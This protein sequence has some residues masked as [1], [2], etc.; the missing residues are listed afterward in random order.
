[1]NL[2]TISEA[3]E[4]LEVSIKELLAFKEHNILKPFLENE[5][6]IFYTPEQLEEF[7]KMMTDK[8]I[9]PETVAP[10][11][12]LIPI[13]L[14]ETEEITTEPKSGLYGVLIK[15]LGNEF[16]SDEFI[17]NYFHSQLQES[18]TFTLKLPN[19]KKL[20]LASSALFILG[21]GLVTQ[22]SRVKYFYGRIEEKFQRVN[23]NGASVLAAQTSKVKLAGNVIFSLPVEFKQSANIAKNLTVGGT[24][25]FKGNLTAPN[26][27]YG[28]KAGEHILITG[29]ESQTPTISVD[30][31]GTVSSINGATGDVTLEAGTDISIDGLTINNISTLATI[32]QRGTCDSC[33][34][35]A[36]VSNNLTIT[37]GGNVSGDA[38][39]T[40]IVMPGVGGTG[41]TTYATGDLIYASASDTLANLPIGDTTGKVLTVDNGIP[42]WSNFTITSNGA[43]DAIFGSNVGIGAAP[44]DLDADFNRFALEVHGSIGPDQNNL[45]DLGSPTKQYRN[46]YLTGQTTSGGNITIANT[47]PTIFLIDTD[48]GQNQYTIN[49]DN[50]QFTITNSTTGANALTAEA[51]GN[52]DLAG[53]SAS[54]GCTIT[55]ASGDLTCSGNITTTNTSGTVGFF[56]RNNATSTL[57]PATAGDSITTGGNLSTT[58]TGAITSAGLLTA[59]NGF[60]QTTGTLNIS[61]NGDS[62]IDAAAN[63]L[64]ITS[65][66]FSTTATGINSTAIGATT[67][68]TGAFTSLSAQ[69]GTFSN[70]N[71]QLTLGT[72]STTIIN[73]AAGA[74]PETATIPALTGP[75]TFVMVSQSQTLDN[76]TIGSTGLIFSNAT[77]D[78][79]TGTNEDFTITPNGSGQ[80]VLSNIVRMGSL[81]VAGGAATTLCRDNASNEVTQCPANSSNVDLQQ[82]Y[83]AGNAINATDAF[84][85]I[86][87]SLDAASSRAF[88]LTNAGTAASA[89]VINDTNVATQNALEIQSGGVTS[90]T[91]DENGSLST[92]GNLTTTGTGTITS[93]GSITSQATSNQIILGT[94]NTTTISSTAP[95]ASRTAT[96]PALSGNDTFV[97]E[98]E[99]QTLANKTIGTSGLVF[100]AAATD[101]TTGTNEDFTISPNGTGQIVLSNTAVLG[102]LIAPTGNA[103]KTLCRDAVTQQITECPA[104]ANN[105][106]LQLAYDTGNTIT[107]TDGRNIDFTLASGLTTQTSFA[108]TNAGTGTAFVLNDTNLG[109]NTSLAIQSGG[110]TSLS[111]TENGTVSTSGNISTTGS[112]A[113]TSAGTLTAGNGLT[114]T[115]GALNLTATSGALA[116]SGLGAS[117][118]SAGT[119]NLT[120]TSGNFNTTATGINGTAIGA[121][122][123]S[124]G[125]FTTLSANGTVTFSTLNAAGVV[126]NDASGIL[127]TEAQLAPARGGTGVDASAAAN[128]QLLIG[129]GTGFTLATLTG[130]AN[131][132][133]VAN[134]SGSITLST[135]QDIATTSTP[136]FA[137]LTV[138]TTGL[139]IS[140]AATD[141]TTGANEDLTVAPNGTGKINLSNTTVLGTLPAAP[142]A[143][144]TLC[145]DDTT[146][147][148]TQ[149]PANAS[150][151][152]LQLA[153]DAGNTITTTTGRNI[154]FTLYDESSN[155]GTATSFDLTNAGTASAFVLNDTNA[156]TNT[157]LEIQS[158]GVTAMTINENGTLSTTG[159]ISTT[160]SGTITSAGTLT[161]SNGLTQ[162]TGTLNLTATAGALTLS[163]LSASSINTGANNLVFTSGNFNT[164]AT[165][166]NGTAIGAT[167]PSTGAFTTLSAQSAALTD[168]TNQL[169]LGTTN[170]TTISSAAPSAS[171]T[172]TIPAL[173]GND[174]FVFENQAQTL[175]NKTFVDT[176]TTFQNQTDNTKQFIFDLSP[177]TT[178]TT[179][180]ITVPDYDGTICLTT[181]NCAGSGGVV[182]GTG[183]QN[184]IT[185]FTVTGSTIGDSNI[186]DDGTVIT[187]F[188]ALNIGDQTGTDTLS[189]LRLSDASAGTQTINSNA[190]TFQGAY[191][192]GGISNNIGFSLQNTVTGTGPSYQL[193]FLDNGGSPVAALTNTG[194]LSLAGTTNQL[195][196][197]TT[198]TTTI[199]STAPAASRTATIPALTG[200]DTFVFEN[201]TQTLNNKTVGS[202][203]L[204]FSGAAPDIT[205]GTNEDFTVSPNG[206]GQI[207]LSNT[208]V[209]N[210]LP[211]APALATTLCRDDTT[212]EITQCPANA[213]NITLQLAYDKGN[214]ILTTDGRD[215]AFTLASGLTTPTSFTLTNAGTASAFVL[216]DTNGATNTAIEIQSGGVTAMT[217]N[218]NGTL[219]TTG[220]LSTTGSG[221]ITSAGTITAQA[222]TNQLVL[223]SGNTTTISSTAPAASRTATIP[224]LTGNDTFVFENET[225]TLTNKTIG[226][227]GLVFSNAATDITT[228]TN[229]DLTL[230]PD[231]TGKI[232]LSNTTVLNSLPAA[233][234]AGTTLCRDNTT[235]QITQC[236]ANA[237]NISLQLAYDA[238]NT[239][240]TTT[241]RDIAFTLY[242][243]SS[244]SGTATHFDLTNAGTGTAFILNDT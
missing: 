102:T 9:S 74:A 33:I 162:T 35:D 124:T 88:T 140:G 176:S 59:S 163:G 199:S 79:T 94:G 87:F 25:E 190:L 195:V 125:A 100:S 141:I 60:T 182:G 71:N 112:G 234:A 38:I 96:I 70:T 239:I 78:V 159:N 208:S 202:A 129:N 98:N 27:L 151:V 183:T 15:W 225:Q 212:H 28:L 43:N 150:N 181:G 174:T 45:Y 18:L 156:A 137:G 187:A 146:H 56:S 46:L 204:V 23:Q 166:I 179:R 55:D 95:L 130:T 105:T 119:N 53:G 107:T 82:A 206:S 233:G 138:G 158:G 207:V 213:A 132:V 90:M 92:S 64:T 6:G 1:M 17:K 8:D 19:R 194:T 244:N 103:V 168:T 3:A 86:A 169:V 5:E 117:S 30:L 173:T 113:I 97:F 154:S 152:T 227:T 200:N 83:N 66:N 127:S 126:I 229:E 4:Y 191:W 133:N 20:A 72:G 62:T 111:I 21:I 48:P 218:E 24:G 242:D 63:Q 178:G 76:K 128:G 148:I 167:T 231:G 41:L 226:T 10:Q 201:Q 12:P 115:T 203:G 65:A 134:A 99:T 216:N 121:T 153:Y 34:T 197:G 241:G 57:T 238:G 68:S 32:A 122:T 13:R 104:N 139:T 235:N 175:T 16:Y 50:S 222:T 236:P 118:V 39:K 143:A 91:I 120:F 160:G 110:V 188:S 22:Q 75:D 108:L 215:I 189:L 106:T 93:A 136:T 58:G 40:G 52:V 7:A 161:A 85:D 61:A 51:N 209:L 37:S 172:A 101:V 205:T 42:A 147:E 223:G 157:A 89:F 69:T 232:V 31:N 230:A 142:V 149:C 192:S 210:S 198:N 49:V 217:I 14:S 131:Q 116:L 219:S 170:T 73:A 2:L 184:R 80:I 196:L 164:T 224:A 81:P 114:Q 36:D 193:S 135:P 29:Q 240:T 145:R 165:G 11:T 237:A 67:P 171:R 180:T 220:N 185:K 177:I 54:T 47:S 186:S 26:I 228:G 123:P 221:T 84:G 77:T 211:A 44:S 214:T 243:E 155:S 109:T 144:T